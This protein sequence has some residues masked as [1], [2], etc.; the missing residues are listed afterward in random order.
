MTREEVLTLTINEKKIKI[1]HSIDEDGK[2]LKDQKNGL[3]E[4]KSLI[5]DELKE[6]KIK[7]YYPYNNFECFVSWR[8]L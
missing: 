6:N 7:G 3:E 8:V 2:F 5:K 4:V 1:I